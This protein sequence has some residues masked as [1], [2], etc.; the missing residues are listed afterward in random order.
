MKGY[1]VFDKDLSCKSLQYEVGK[2]YEMVDHPLL[3][4]K[5]FHFCQNVNDVFMYY[6]KFSRMCEVEAIGEIITEKNKSVTNKIKILRE[7]VGKELS[8]IYYGSGYGDNNYFGDGFGNS[9]GYGYNVGYNL[10]Y[11]YGNSN[12]YSN[13]NGYGCGA[14]YGYEYS[15]NGCNGNDGYSGD[16]ENIQKIL[17]WR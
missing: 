14:G 9:Y 8:K 3:C 4:M 15:G 10:G 12:S 13:G 11:G 17:L 1:K 7:I 16:G 2:T 5:G 6:S